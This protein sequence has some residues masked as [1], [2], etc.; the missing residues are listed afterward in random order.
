MAQHKSAIKAHKQSLKRA[1]RNKSIKSKIKT[2]TKKLEQLVNSKDF[3]KA[4]STLGQVESAIMKSVTKKVLKLNTA[5][6]KVSRLAK[7]VKSLET[8]N[9]AKA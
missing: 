4:K 1:L 8:S 7:K 2:L 6:R 9:A 5:S 3:E